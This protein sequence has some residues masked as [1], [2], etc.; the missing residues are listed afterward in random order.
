MINLILAVDKNFCIGKNNW[1]CWNLK[2]DLKFFSE[3]TKDSIVIMWKNTYLSLPEQFRPLPN[4]INF[5]VS[6]T[7]RVGY[8]DDND[9]IS[10]KSKW[11]SD[12]KMITNWVN[13]Y[14]K[15]DVNIQT[16]SLTWKLVSWIEIFP[17]L[18]QAIEKA[19]TLWKEIFL[20]GWKS[21]YEQGIKL[22][23]KVYLTKVEGEFDCDVCLGNEFSQILNQKF[24]LLHKSEVFEENGIKF[25][26]CEY[27]V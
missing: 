4:R 3:K 2:K 17:S 18:E 27:V 12:D 14:M 8:Q 6:K 1:L 9:D 21:I 5:V 24:K 13:N 16:K 25:Y 26:F 7:L 22:A 11:Y 20:I 23:D 10:D 15:L 19:K